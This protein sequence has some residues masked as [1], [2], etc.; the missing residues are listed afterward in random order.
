[1]V[2]GHSDQEMV[3]L[4]NVNAIR[5]KELQGCFSVLRE[6]TLHHSG[7]PWESAPEVSGAACCMGSTANIEK[8]EAVRKHSQYSVY[9]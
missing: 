7:V 1:M 8:E 2:L 9:K 6:Q 5:K 3:Q 4:K